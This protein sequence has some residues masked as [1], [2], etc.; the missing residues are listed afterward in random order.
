MVQEDRHVKDE[1]LNLLDQHYISTRYTDDYKNATFWVWYRAGKPN[2]KILHG[3]IE[4]TDDGVLPSELALKDWIYKVFRPKAEEV[5][6]ELNKRVAEK[7]ITEKVEML[8]RHTALGKFMQDTAKDYLIAHK[9]E[10]KP[11]TALK[12]LVDGI[13]IERK[14]VGLPGLITETIDTSTESLQKQ[15]ENLLNMMDK[16]DLALIDDGEE[17][18]VSDM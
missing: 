11:N 9:D 1:T 16:D 4:P 14:S 15:V 5:D 13:E 2:G 8:E 18:G 17:D 7:A 12:M 6:V 10:L 3:L